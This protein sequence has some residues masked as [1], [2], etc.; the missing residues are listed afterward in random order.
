MLT[1]GSDSESVMR[2][3][4]EAELIWAFKLTLRTL[5][6]AMRK[7]LCGHERRTFEQMLA[8]TLTRKTLANFEV[9]AS[10]DPSTVTDALFVDA[11][12]GTGQGSAPLAEQ[13]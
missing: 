9:L 5:S 13:P 6:A 12:Y 2:Q 4:S 11:A 8:E 10:G 3:A 1:A 7:G